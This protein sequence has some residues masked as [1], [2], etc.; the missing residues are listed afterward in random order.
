MHC[1]LSQEI[2]SPEEID[3]DLVKKIAEYN[4]LEYAGDDKF[5]RKIITCSA[6]QLPNDDQIKQTE[7]RNLDVFF[8]YL[9][10]YVLK[11]FEQ[12]VTSDYVI[13]YFHDGL[14]SLNR[15]SYTW[16]MRAY[17]HIDRK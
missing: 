7:Y 4:I 1:V 17:R 3:V 14:N 5:G 13:V 2:P 6:C 9:F 11:T 10:D 8:D 16:L 15:P 12:Y